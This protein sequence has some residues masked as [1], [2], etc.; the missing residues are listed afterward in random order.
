MSGRSLSNPHVGLA[1]LALPTML[2]AM[3]MTILYLATPS[4]SA[5]LRPTGAQLLWISDI[6]AF[7]IAG[8][9]IPLGVLG[10]GIGRRKIL[11]VGAGFFG[12][13]SIFAAFAP[14]AEMLIVARALLG[15]AGA[16]LLPSTLALIGV[17]FPDPERRG[18]AIGIWA[19]CFTLGGVIG[20][21]FGGILIESFWWGSVFLAGVPMMVLLLILGPFFLPEYKDSEG[22]PLDLLS[23]SLLLTAILAVT[24][25]MKST[26]QDGPSLAAAG[27]FA[28]GLVVGLVFVRRQRSL[29]SPMIDLSLFSRPAFVGALGA[30]MMALFAWV[31]A[32]LLVAHYLQLV[33]GLSP[34]AAGLWTIPPAIASMIGCLGAPL[35][36]RRH[37]PALLV[38]GALTLVSLSL[39]ALAVFGKAG[40]LATIITGMVGLGLGVATIVTLGTDVVLGEAPE[41]KSGAAAAMSETGAELGAALGVAVLG[42]VSIALYRATI[43]IPESMA[44][45]LAAAA[46]DT[47]GAAAE[48]S[49]QTG[50]AGEDLLR[51]AQDAFVHGFQA[52]SG[53]GAAFLLATTAL[54][55]IAVAR[56][57][58][59]EM[60]QRV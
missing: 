47:L 55:A 48:V 50:S 20:P 39:A 42:S 22:H 19:M 1:V 49:T 52:A 9:L 16:T 24:F 37:R 54:F 33:H 31:G 7:V 21:L 12:L 25:T 5:E 35:V 41:S 53:V 2:V 28:A 59:P 45:D 58:A 30:N 26:A 43:V 23:A 6:Y 11:L 3:D 14:T 17:L 27:A 38:L 51:S 8:A 60:D 13:A 15:L 4:L 36:A 32:S 40:G 46:R 34:F 18:A 56:R 44:S 10:D 29:A 57:T